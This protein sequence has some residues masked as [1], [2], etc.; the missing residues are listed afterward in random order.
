M[1]ESRA[2]CLTSVPAAVR[3][4]AVAA[5]VMPPGCPF[6]IIVLIQENAPIGVSG[7]NAQHPPE[8]KLGSVKSI[9]DILPGRLASSVSSDLQSDIDSED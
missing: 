8:G 3:R 1:A 7:G 2:E 4:A 6:G 9:C 5:A